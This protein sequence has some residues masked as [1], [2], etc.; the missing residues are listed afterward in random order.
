MDNCTVGP[1]W[2][3]ELDPLDKIYCY[4]ATIVTFSL[5]YIV[6][7]QQH[8]A[9]TDSAGEI[10]MRNCSTIFVL[11]DTVH[12]LLH[13]GD[14]SHSCNLILVFIFRVITGV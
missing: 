13:S 7:L 10:L 9:I 1:P 3:I 8:A 2:H 12:P 5:S 14:N 6:A 11:Y 4:I